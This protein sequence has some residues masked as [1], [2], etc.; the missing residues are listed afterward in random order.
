MLEE[1]LTSKVVPPV[2]LYD[3]ESV[4]YSLCILCLKLAVIVPLGVISLYAYYISEKKY[5]CVKKWNWKY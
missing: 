5:L 4:M 2:T 1:I 3:E